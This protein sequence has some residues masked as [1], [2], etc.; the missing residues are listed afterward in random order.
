MT[1]GTVQETVL[2][3][4]LVILNGVRFGQDLGVCKLDDGLIK[5]PNR[6]S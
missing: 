5:N 1:I 2:A 4:A 3:A 6:K